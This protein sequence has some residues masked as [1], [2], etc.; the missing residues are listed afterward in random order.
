M[1]RRK[2]NLTVQA[3]LLITLLSFAVTPA[4]AFDNANGPQLPEQCINH[5]AIEDHSVYSERS[6]KV[7]ASADVI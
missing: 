6:L 7:R 1:Y 5:A 4:S 2:I 3:L